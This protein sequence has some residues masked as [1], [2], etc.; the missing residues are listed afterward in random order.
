VV[1]GVGMHACEYMTRGTVV[2]L[3][4]A[5]AN[6]GA[7]MTGGTL[8]LRKRYLPKLETSY[9]EPVEWDTEG[10]NELRALLVDYLAETGSTTAREALNDLSDF[11]K[12][13]PVKVY[14]K[15]KQ[16]VGRNDVRENLDGASGSLRV[17]ISVPGNSNQLL[18]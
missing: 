13:V 4:E 15:S 5:G 3:G 12:I 11:V 2:V 6:V 8:Y 14:E 17:G 1:E 10:E 9:L 7:G 18:H 16:P